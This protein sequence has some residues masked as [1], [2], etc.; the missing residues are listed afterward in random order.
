MRMFR[1][2]WEKCC[3]EYRMWF[4]LLIG[5]DIVFGLFLWLA[6]FK[7]FLELSGILL[8]FTVLVFVSA[9]IWMCQRDKKIEALAQEYLDSPDEENGEYIMRMLPRRE[10]RQLTAAGEMLREKESLLAQQRCRLEEYEEFIESWAHEI[11]TPLAL[12]TLL[13]DNRR[14]EI[15]PDVYKR[16]EYTRNQMQGYVDRILFY[17]RLKAVH[18]D[19]F[20]EKVNLADCV[21]EVLDEYQ[22]FFHEGGVEV[23]E[24]VPTDI[25]ATADKKCLCFIIGQLLNN[26]VKYAGTKERTPRM[27]V[28]AQMEGKTGKAVLAVEDN[29]MGIK[30][31]DLPFIFDKGFT[32]D[33]AKQKKKST[34]MG[35]YL[36]KQIADELNIKIDV[37]SVYGM[38]TK[39]TITL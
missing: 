29:G 15:V 4:G 19:Y 5:T 12:L 37:Q 9:V 24:Q 6:D 36:V 18:K 32:G 13:L 17:A 11:K 30:S 31:G 23:K 38:G 27:K 34:G 2:I 25:F 28:W 16:L 35:L 10:A 3:R 39:I 20:L 1:E 14:D 8:F 26:A 22:M 33:S 7:S 21:K